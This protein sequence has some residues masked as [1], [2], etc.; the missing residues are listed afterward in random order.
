MRL[1]IIQILNA[2]LHFSKE[3]I[4]LCQSLRRF[5]G[6]QPRFGNAL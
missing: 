3:N 5:W 6:H 1:L 2:M 4:R